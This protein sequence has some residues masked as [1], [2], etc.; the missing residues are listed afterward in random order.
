MLGKIKT[1]FLI[2]T[3]LLGFIFIVATGGGSSGGGGNYSIEITKFDWII[4]NIDPSYWSDPPGTATC[5]YNF[6][7]SYEGDNIGVNAI[8]SARVYLPSGSAWALSADWLNPKSKYIGGWGR[9]WWNGDLG[10]S[11]PI[12]T[13][14]AEIILANGNTTTYNQTIPV[15]GSKT[16]NGFSYVYTEDYVTSDSDYTPMLKRATI[17]SCKKGG[18]TI[19]IEFSVSDSNVYNGYVDFY[20]SEGY[21]IAQTKAL[22]RNTDTGVLSDIINSG[23]GFHT[24][25]SVNLLEITN[26]DISF[27]TGYEYA[28]ILKVMVVLRDGAQYGTRVPDYHCMSRSFK[29]DFSNL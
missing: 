4:E 7:I 3:I 11:L 10:N 6:W 15:P 1:V 22:F 29:T 26:G 13:L 28:D 18:G 9:W 21:F 14:T 5:F 20:N 16:S 8:E 19:R 27:E 17:E 12:G 23:T 2:T 24:N 25:G